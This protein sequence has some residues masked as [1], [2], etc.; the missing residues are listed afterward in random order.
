M[1]SDDDH[2]EGRPSLVLAILATVL[3]HA[4]F[5]GL[6]IV[7]LLILNATVRDWLSGET[8]AVASVVIGFFGILMTLIGTGFFWVAYVGGPRFLGGIEREREKYR[9]RPWLVNRH[10]RA[11]RVVHSRRF[12]IWFM[13][14]W[15]VAWWA[16]LGIFWTVNKDLMLADLRGSWDRAAPVVLAFAAGLAGMIVAAA[17]TWRR[18][19]YGDAVLL[20]DTLPGFLGERFRGRVQM[21]RAERPREPVELAL[22]CLSRRWVRRSGG[23]GRSTTIRVD[24]E[25]WRESRNLQPTQMTFDRGLITL[26]VSFELPPDLPESGHLHDEPPQIV[27]ELAVKTSPATGQ[28]AACVFEVPVFEQRDRT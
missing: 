24:E 15:C 20:I 13:W 4:L 25:L 8:E 28:S 17:L 3:V 10:W 9:D 12:D 19:R 14:F 16:M 27:W 5:A 18:W 22:A 11:R 21:R 7:G 6:A 1:G 2:P 26:P 23:H